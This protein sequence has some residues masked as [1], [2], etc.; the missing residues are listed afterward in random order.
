MLAAADAEFKA[1]AESSG[2]R[3]LDGDSAALVPIL[4]ADG[5]PLEQGDR[6]Y[7]RLE[8]AFRGVSTAVLKRLA[9]EPQL[10]RQL[11]WRDFEQLVAE[12]F[13]R[14]GFEVELTPR[15]G[16]SGVDLFAAR[17]IG[18]GTVLY[19]VECKRYS[20]PIGPDFVRQLA[21][22]VERHRAT[23]GVLATTS[24]FT[25]GAVEEQRQIEFRMT[26]ADYSELRTWLSGRPIL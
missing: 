22:V 5:R 18:L 20:R 19:A 24:R 25:R 15:G 3:Q 26:L 17:R 16:D 9:D 23:G 12:L 4:G 21:W 14:D 13:R 8:V 6:A 10:L 1:A 11:H 7:T 2:D